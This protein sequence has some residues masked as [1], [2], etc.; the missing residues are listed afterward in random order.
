MNGV[1]LALLLFAQGGAV[2]SAQTGTV[3]GRVFNM[4]GS[5]AARIRVAA[6]SMAESPAAAAEAP[7]LNSIVLTDAQGNYRL[8]GVTP[9][10]FYIEAGWVD[11]PTYYPGVISITEARVVTVA[12]GAAITGIDFKMGRPAGLTVRGRVKLEAGALMPPNAR[13][14]MTGGGGAI[15]NRNVVPPADGT[16]AFDSVPPGR[17]TIGVSPTNG[18]SPQQIVVS[19]KDLEIE[20]VIKP[21]VVAS[22]RVVVEGGGPRPRINLRFMSGTSS[23]TTAGVSPTGTFNVQLSPGTYRL[24]AGGVP[25]G[26]KLKSIAAGGM[27][28]IKDEI[29]VQVG[30]PL[31]EFVVTLDVDSPPAWVKVKGRITGGVAPGLN[32]TLI[33]ANAG[34]I[35]RADVGSDGTFEFPRVIPGPYTARPEGLRLAA[36]GLNAAA[37]AL[38]INVGSGDLD[39]LEIPL[40]QTVNVSGRVVVDGNG[41]LGGR[42]LGFM[43][44][45]NGVP[46]RL[47][48]ALINSDGR[49]SLILPVGQYSLSWD[50]QLSNLNGFSVKSL[51]YGSETVLGKPIKVMTEDAG[52]ELVVTLERS[53]PGGVKVIG[54]VTNVPGGIAQ[55]SILGTGF[56]IGGPNAISTD[57]SGVFEIPD[58]PP[59]SFTLRAFSMAAGIDVSATVNVLPGKD[60][61][62]IEIP[63]PPQH[64]TDGKIVSDPDNGT[65]FL[66]RFWLILAGSRS[67]TAYPKVQADGSF[68]VRLPLGEW[69]VN[70]GG[71]SPDVTLKAFNYGDKNLLMEKI[72]V[73]ANDTQQLRIGVAPNQAMVKVGGRIILPSQLRPVDRLMR[74]N[75]DAAV[76][77]TVNADG[78]FV[79]PKVLPATYT[80]CCNYGWTSITIPNR[81]VADLTLRGISGRIVMEA[82]T[83]DTGLYFEANDGRRTSSAA[84]VGPDGSFTL[85]LAEGSY[86]FEMSALPAGTTIKSIRYGAL[87]LSNQIFAFTR[88]VAIADLTVTIGKRP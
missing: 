53:G 80:W 18:T 1:V 62:G 19:D 34:E 59:G 16:F 7:V 29:V 64:G 11:L 41:S 73:V 75:G 70:V 44:S 67:I 55:V 38:Q 86:R 65:P 24:E 21:T 54:R 30:T 22:G 58:V 28:W 84:S 43:I 85:I 56:D 88:D 69:N 60:L 37:A 76:E 27:D 13:V 2:P 46:G 14:L 31:P 20:L 23:V 63:F 12:G 78:T 45:G 42:R 6:Q 9:G 71:L 51:T 74:L 61:T 36:A 32:V 72:N 77:T 79:F 83:L 4:D 68:T 52:K 3:S 82:G 5:P 48:T 81:D 17:Y 15:T 40:P 8:E 57:A 26:Y 33:G 35:L 25:S 87:D 66:P 49:F 50:N 10:R 39:N 47:V